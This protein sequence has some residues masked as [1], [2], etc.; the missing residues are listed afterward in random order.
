MLLEVRN[1]H[2]GYGDAPAIWDV[3]LDID[4]GKIVSVVGPNGAGKSTLINAIAGIL[5][6]S[7][8]EVL[9]EGADTARIP[10][11]R[12]CDHG[13][14]IVPEGR[15]LFT[16]MT[17]LENLELG[18]YRSAARGSRQD[19]LEE[20]FSLFPIIKERCHQISGS[21]SGGQQQMVAI[22]RALMA[23]PRLLLMDEP[24]LGL[25]P[26]LVDDMFSIIRTINQRGVAVLLVEQNINKALGIAHH[27][28]VIEQ[29]RI[30]T[31]GEPGA[32]L[33]NPRIREAYL[34]I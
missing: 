32:L 16:N 24:S 11:Y 9:I 3:S 29:G 17:V 26:A 2:V 34:G 30:V 21:M 4:A 33:G 23:R 28:Y 6:P 31:S 13:V 27:A 20:V 1:L 18:S 25:A 14:A 19:T 7:R 8:G 10:G 5:R 15:R 12:V 22:G